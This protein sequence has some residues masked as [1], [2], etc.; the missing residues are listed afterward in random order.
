VSLHSIFRIAGKV[1]DVQVLLDLFE[2]KLHLPF[3][4]WKAEQQKVTC[5]LCLPEQR[6]QFG[7]SWRIE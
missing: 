1:F 6:R 7:N 2:E 5:R 4:V 3:V